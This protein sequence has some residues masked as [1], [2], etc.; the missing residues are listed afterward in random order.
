MYNVKREL[1]SYFYV[2]VLQAPIKYH[3]QGFRI[4]APV[5]GYK[6]GGTGGVVD[7][8]FKAIR[9]FKNKL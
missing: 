4:L 6:Y 3:C 1:A 2:K 5:V 7:C 8:F 9:V